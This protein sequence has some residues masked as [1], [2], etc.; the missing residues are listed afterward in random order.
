[1]HLTIAYITCRTEPRIE[2]FLRTLARQVKP[3]DCIHVILV[4]FYADTPGRSDWRNCV[5]NANSRK[6]ETLKHVPPKPT[7]WQGRHR[8]TRRDYFA[9]ANARNTALA[10]CRTEFIAFIDDLS[11]LG[12]LWLDQVR[13]AEHHQYTVLGAYK[14]VLNLDVQ[15]SGEVTFTPHPKGADSRWH[16]G[17]DQGIVPASGSWLFGCSFALPLEHALAVNGFDE[18]CDGAGAEDY[19][20]GIRLQRWGSRIHYNRNMLTYESEEGHAGPGSAFLRVAKPTD[21]EGQ[22]MGSDHVLLRRVTNEART[23]TLA[24]YTDLHALRRHLA[25]ACGEFP[26]PTGPDVDW[27]DGTPLSEM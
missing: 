14:K 27:R 25:A 26:P 8:K 11:A 17:S 22:R 9:A 24:Q 1:M 2:W 20:F 6:V 3:E 10:L 7:V 12:P 16:A 4:D 19:D 21:W 5:F 18:I 15:P 23:T 13:H